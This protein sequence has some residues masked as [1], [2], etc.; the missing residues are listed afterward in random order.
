M[1]PSTQSTA[2]IRLPTLAPVDVRML[3]IKIWYEADDMQQLLYN[4]IESMDRFILYSIVPASESSE[5][6][7]L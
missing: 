6:L 3:G 4:P 5:V 7:R 2:S 1:T